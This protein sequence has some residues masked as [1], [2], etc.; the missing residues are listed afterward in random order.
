MHRNTDRPRLIGNRTG[1]RLT[2]PPSG[3]SRKLIAAAIFE[4]VNRLH[5]TDV[6]FLNQIQELQ[7]AVGILFGNRNYQPQIGLDHFL[8]GTFGF[9]FALFDG[10]DHPAVFGNR[11]SAFLRHAGNAVAQFQHF[12]AVLGDKFLPVFVFFVRNVFYP[13][14]VKLRLLISFQKIFT[15]DFA[16]QSITQ[17]FSLQ[18]HQAFVK[19][20]QLFHQ[21]FDP[22][23]VEVNG[24]HQFDQFLLDLN[25]FLFNRR[26]DALAGQNGLHPLALDFLQIV[27]IAGD[28]GKNFQHRFPQRLFHGGDGSGRMT[29]HA[30]AGIVQMLAAVGRI[31]V[32]FAVNVGSVLVFVRAVFVVNG[33]FQVHVVFQVLVNIVEIF[34]FFQLGYH[35]FQ[36]VDR[37]AFLVFVNEGFRIIAVHHFQIDHVAQLHFARQK[38]I[39]PAGD[40]LNRHRAFAQAVDHNRFAGLNPL[41]DRNF[42][43]TGEQFDR[44][45]FF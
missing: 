38:V 11:Q 44:P 12:G 26:L 10:I 16:C 41:G 32:A 45:H 29:A 23:R 31:N 22:H 27:I 24:T 36:A 39:F 5:Q 19:I 34:L 1:N 17:Q 28:F 15:L 40:G 4:F 33:V 13:V 18:P 42:P 7:P 3:I 6:A 25:I 35:F 37:R 9:P 21:L 20:V 14:G 30:V 43:F 8:F 2:D